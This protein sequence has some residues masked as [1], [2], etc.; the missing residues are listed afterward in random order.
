M[1][2]RSRNYLLLLAFNV[3]LAICG[4]FLIMALHEDTAFYK[5][6]VAVTG[7]A[8]AALAIYAIVTATPKAASHEKLE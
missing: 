1:S 4:L 6:G 8:A 2:T 7:L 5:A 3:V